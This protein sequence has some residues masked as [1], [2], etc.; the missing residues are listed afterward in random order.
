MVVPLQLLS[1][2]QTEWLA[3]VAAAAALAVATDGANE[4]SLA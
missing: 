1:H 3:A 4:A 2:S